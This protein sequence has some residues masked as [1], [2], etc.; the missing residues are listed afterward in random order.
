MRLNPPMKVCKICF[1]NFYNDSLIHLFNE[2][3][4]VC[5]R[6][7]EEIQAKFIK[8]DIDGISGLSIYDYDERI[9]S[10]IYQFKGCF[11]YE[12]KDVFLSRYFRELSLRYKG[13]VVVPIPSSKEDD[14][15]RDFNHVVEIF[16]MLKLQM[17]FLLRKTGRVKQATSNS[18]QRKDISK[19]LEL[20]DK[21]DLTKR[22]ILIVDDVYTTGST[23]HA[24]INLIQQLHPKKIKVL[25]ISKTKLE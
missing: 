5:K 9:Q 16:K 17:L 8:F 19:Y 20:I 21:P 11:D 12:L 1:H 4:C 22:K 25:V 6:C 3:L 23:M 10:L 18:K 2:K 13:Y 24:A 7:L 14:E 15:E